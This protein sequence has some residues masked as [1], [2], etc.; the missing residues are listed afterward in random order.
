MLVRLCARSMCRGF[1]GTRALSSGESVP[2]SRL[3][4][5]VREGYCSRPQL[6]METLSRDIDAAERELAE[7]RP[8]RPPEGELRA[9]VRV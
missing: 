3:Y 2:P 1:S 9:L 7:R 4:E 6:D 8:G 5:Y